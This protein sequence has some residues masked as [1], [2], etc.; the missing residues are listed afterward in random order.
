ME[1]VIVAAEHE[2]GK[3]NKLKLRTHLINTSAVNLS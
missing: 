1:R 2:G 3:F